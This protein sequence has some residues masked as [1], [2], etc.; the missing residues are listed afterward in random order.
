MDL[1]APDLP[2][3]APNELSAFISTRRPGLGEAL[4]AQVQQGF[5]SS[6]FGAVGA[7]GR[8]VQGA[9]AAPE[10]LA[11][12]DW[13]AS[14]LSRPR[15]QWD[16]RM[17]R[18]RAEAMAREYDEREYRRRLLEARDPG[19]AETALGFGAQL[20]GAIPSPENF[21]PF[22]GP[23]ARGLRALGAT[24][25]ADTLMAPGVG[26]SALRG[27]T[28]ATIGTAAIMPLVLSVDA[29]YGEDVTFGRVVG[30]LAIG[31]LIGT[32]FGT[33]G[34]L[35]SRG[36]DTRLAPDTMAAVR[37]VD[38]AA[39]DIAAGRPIVPPAEMALRAVEDAA[40][41]SAPAELRGVPLRE[42]PTRPDGAPLS[43]EE[44]AEEWARRVTGETDGARALS[45]IR[46]MERQQVAQD[47]EVNRGGISLVN[48]LIR[49]GGVRDDGG[50]VRTVMGGARRPGLLNN[51]GRSLDE[52]VRAA[53]E[54]GFFDDLA[55]PMSARMEGAAPDPL[56][57]RDLVDAIENELKGVGIRRQ[58]ISG[59]MAVPEARDVIASRYEGQRNAD[60]DQA[61]DQYQD[62]FDSIMERAAIMEFDGGLS[63]RAAMERA[64]REASDD[65]FDW[66]RE[67]LDARQQAQRLMT[68]PPEAAMPMEMVRPETRAA[69]AADPETEAAMAQVEALRAEGRLTAGDEAI[70][71]AG[72]EQ[73]QQFEALSRG[74]EAAGACLLRNLA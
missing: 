20:L 50:D 18:G 65:A 72:D 8:E 48:W 35:L 6:G 23:A 1:T 9:R 30:E 41:R 74:Q 45:A 26:A 31:A 12:E 57:P 46:A 55:A 7:L 40:A 28:D 68:A 10:L 43:R 17:T 52:A 47:M 32:G 27:A 70:L 19:A 16:E 61:F 5:Q 22:A 49:T 36:A 63:R 69:D 39:R 64:I 15:L 56:A 14:G 66:Y 2:D 4:G 71:R 38:A 67:A 44:F 34:G 42:L 73:A 21:V 37:T 24:R 11:R 53:R 62:A 13:E 29:R 60:I 54:A 25:A 59:P 58:G 51:R 3:I 33:I